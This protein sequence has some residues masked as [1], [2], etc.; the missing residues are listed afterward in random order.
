MLFCKAQKCRVDVLIELPAV[1]DWSDDIELIEIDWFRKV[2]WENRRLL[3]GILRSLFAFTYFA[4]P[5]FGYF[6]R[7]MLLVSLKV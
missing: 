3:R 6:V 5:L 4:P 7:E 1:A 2:L